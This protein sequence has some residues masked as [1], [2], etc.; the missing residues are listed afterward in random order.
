MEPRT[1][2]LSYIAPFRS[3]LMGYYFF[4]KWKEENRMDFVGKK[5]LQ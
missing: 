5:Q 4:Y 1:V 3:I 2:L